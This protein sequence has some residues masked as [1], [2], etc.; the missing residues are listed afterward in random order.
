ME[1]AL[2]HYLSSNS[3]LPFSSRARGED[4][5]MCVTIERERGS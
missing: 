5:A 4:E 1:V 2:K 3:P